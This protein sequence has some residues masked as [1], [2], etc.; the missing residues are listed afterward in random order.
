MS[1]SV[2]S[3]LMAGAAAATATTL[4]LTP[5]QVVPADVAVPAHPTS[6]QPHLTEAMV[7]LLAAA[8]NMAPPAPPKLPAASVVPAVG[9]NPLAA[10]PLAAAPPGAPAPTNAASDWLTNAYQGIQAWV[11]WGVDYAI[12][13]LYW[14]GWWFW[15]AASLAGQVDIFYN[16][17]IQPISNNIFYYGVV[18]IVNDPLNLSVWTQAIR[19]VVRMSIPPVVNFGIA[20]FNY[21]FGWLIPPIPPM[22][23]IGPL[24]ATPPTLD[25]L[26]QTVHTTLTSVA[27]GLAP[28]PADAKSDPANKIAPTAAE[29]PAKVDPDAKVDA[30]EKGVQT[31]SEAQTTEPQA[32]EPTTDPKADPTTDPKAA[33]KGDPKAGTP[34]AGDTDGPGASQQDKVKTPKPVKKPGKKTETT[35]AD[36]NQTAGNT[37]ATD[38][39][40]GKVHNDKGTKADKGTK[41]NSG[42]GQNSGSEGHAAK[43]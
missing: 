33:P 34:A 17:L 28:A 23:P 37:G 5:I 24:A 2:R 43:G 29:A 22:P 19:N 8:S 1:V 40:P 7:K 32:G 39:K 14:A 3:Y 21:F 38:T 30:P 16:T 42:A 20:E 31:E 25:S 18:P 26:A 6:V 12:E 27:A 41:D 36:T 9:P 15:P 11:D 13:L 10:A 35:N 4:A